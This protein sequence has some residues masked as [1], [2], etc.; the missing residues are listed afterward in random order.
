[1]VIASSIGSLAQRAVG[2]NRLKIVTTTGIYV[3]LV[4]FQLMDG[5]QKG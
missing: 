3:Y 4:F 2:L 5:N 1:M